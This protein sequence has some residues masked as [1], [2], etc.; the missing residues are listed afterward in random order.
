[1]SVIVYSKNNC[2]G[3]LEIKAWL[4]GNDIEFEERNIENE[5]PEV[6]QKNMSELIE[7]GIRSV[8]VTFIGDRNPIVGFNRPKLTEVFSV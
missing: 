4:D 5:N 7:K 3:C 6:A 8:P 1:M 2:P